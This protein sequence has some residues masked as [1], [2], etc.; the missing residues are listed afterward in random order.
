MTDTLVGRLRERLGSI[1]TECMNGDNLAVTL[2]TSFENYEQET[3]DETGWTPDAEAGCTQVLDAIHA[4]YA[5]EIERLTRELAQA[6][7]SYNLAVT[8]RLEWRRQAETTNRRLLETHDA[9]EEMKAR[10]LAAESSLSEAVKALEPFAEIAKELSPSLS[11]DHT[12]TMHWA[13]PSVGDFRKAMKALSAIRSRAA[14]G[15]EK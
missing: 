14:V 15:G 13:V 1:Q 12:N 9:Y 2:C 5:A 11:D 3:S 6:N 10:A 7:K 8:S 4:H